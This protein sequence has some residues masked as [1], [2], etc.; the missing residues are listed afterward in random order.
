MKKLLA[1]AEKRLAQI[2][3]SARKLGGTALFITTQQ[4]KT[5]AAARRRLEYLRDMRR[6]LRV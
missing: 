6:A 1:N 4:H 5:A 2:E 3:I